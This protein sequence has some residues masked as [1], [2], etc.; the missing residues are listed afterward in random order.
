MFTMV[1]ISAGA[2][3]A[4]TVNESAK[5]YVRISGVDAKK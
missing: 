3:A 1:R 4:D 5:S 2:A